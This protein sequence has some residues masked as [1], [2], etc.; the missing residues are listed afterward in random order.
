M[1][2]SSTRNS[3]LFV[4][5]AQAITNCIPSDGGMYA[6]ASSVNLL[7]WIYHMDE[8]TKFESIAGTLTSALL[9]DELSPL[10]SETIAS[11]AFPFSPKLNQLDKNLYVLEL[12][13]G[14]TG[15][16]KDFGV[17]FLASCLEHILLMQEKT[18]IILT[19]TNGETGSSV[20]KALKNKKHVKAVLLYAKGTM[21][22]F[23]ES[24][25]IWNGGNILPI[26]IEGDEKKCFD[27]AREIFTDT[28]IVEKF[29]LTLANSLNI[30]RLLPQ[31]FFYTYAFT[32]LKN[33]THGEIYYALDAGNYGNLTAGL[34]SWKFS[35]PVN[36]FITDCTPALNLDDDG[37][38]FVQDSTIPLNKRGSNDPVKPSNIERLE[39]VFFTNPAVIKGFVFPAY[40]NIR[41]KSY[42][43]NEAF[44][45]YGVLLDS[46]TATAYA[47]SKKRIDITDGSEATVV[48][49]AR[50]HPSFDAEKIYDWCGNKIQLPEHL[51]PLH[52]NIETK[53]KVA[54]NVKQVIETLTNLLQ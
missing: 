5:F 23:E 19:P 30:G 41:E 9:K 14:P 21:R 13:H 26:E 45:K 12:F 4:S 10:I 52:K 20:A 7:P 34:Y 51:K 8:R 37:N 47:A 11:K 32:R 28:E 46:Q 16:H 3:K 43:A 36:G 27:I 39:E 42:A 15:S 49:I 25:C 31:A 35:L 17:S 2:F 48:L 50:D 6:P 22:G 38:A 44:K 1:F 53:H 40:V 33:K 29:S 54:S 24:D 18:A